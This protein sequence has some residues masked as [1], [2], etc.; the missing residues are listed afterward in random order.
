MER[1]KKMLAVYEVEHGVT[2]A[3]IAKAMGTTY[4][5]LWAKLNRKVK[6]GFYLSEAAALSEILGI[7]LDEFYTLTK[8]K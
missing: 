3:Y 1:L 6:K 5:T 7:T 2:G 8:E 4:Q